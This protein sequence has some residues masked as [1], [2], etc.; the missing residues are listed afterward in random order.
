[1]E[2]VQVGST[3]IFIGLGLLAL[4]ILLIL[5]GHFWTSKKTGSLTHQYEDIRSD[6]LPRATIQ[7]LRLRYDTRIQGQVIPTSGSFSLEL[8]DYFPGMPTMGWRWLFT[9]YV[10]LPDMKA[11]NG[12]DFEVFLRPGDYMLVFRAKSKKVEG[13]VK[14]TMTAYIKLFRKLIDVGLVLIQVAL[15]ILVTGFVIYV[16][17]PLT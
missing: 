15:P 12:Q 16:G 8:G 14:L 1:M 10:S 11:G 6:P 5:I 7:P 17:L 3:L 9:A 4:S 2:P 13:S